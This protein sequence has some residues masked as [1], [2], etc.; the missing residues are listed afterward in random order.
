VDEQSIRFDSL[1]G[2]DLRGYFPSLD[3]SDRWAVSFWIKPQDINLGHTF[4]HAEEDANNF[5]TFYKDNFNRLFFEAQIAGVV[6]AQF[7][8]SKFYPLDVSNWHHIYLIF[9][10]L[11]GTLQLFV[12]GNIQ[13]NFDFFTSPTNIAGYS[14]LAPAAEHFVGTDLAATR[15]F[16]GMMADLHCLGTIPPGN[17]N[18]FGSFDGNGTWIRSAFAGPWG[19]E[20]FNLTFG[21][22]IDLGEDFSGNSNDFPVHTNAAGGGADQFDDWMERNYAILDRNDPR[23]LGGITEGGLVL[24]AANGRVTMRPPANSGVYY[25]ERNGVAVTFDT[26]G[27]EFD[28]NLTPATYNFGQLPFVDVGPM[29]GELT[30]NGLNLPV[31]T[32]PNARAQFA[33]IGYTGNATN[34]RTIINGSRGLP[35]HRNLTHRSDYVWVKNMSND[36]GTFGHFLQHR[37]RPG[38]QLRIDTPGPEEASNVDGFL[39]GLLDPGP[40]FDVDAGGTSDD[41]VNHAVSFYSAVSWQVEQYAQNLQLVDTDDDSE[42]EVL[43]GNTDNT[44]SDLEITLEGGGAT[45]QLVGIRFQDLRIPQGATIL[46]ARIQFEAN[47]T[48]TGTNDVVIDCEDID[49]APVF[50]AGAANF[51]ISNRTLTGFTTAWSPADWP[52]FDDRLAPQLTTDFK[53]SVQDV[54]DRG[55]WTEG[56]S[57]VIVMVAGATAGEREAAAEGNGNSAELQ[58]RW[59][60]ATPVPGVSLFEYDG[61][62]SGGILKARNVM[63]GLSVVPEFIA[64]KRVAGGSSSWRIYVGTIVSA[65]APEDGHLEFDSSNAYL[66]S[67]IWDNTAPGASFFTVGTDVSINSV[68]GSDVYAGFAMVS[69]EAFSKVFRYVGNNSSN[70]PLVYLGFKPRF[71]LIKSTAAGADWVFHTKASG[72]S[73]AI[74]SIFNQMDGNMYLNTDVDAIQ[75][76]SINGYSRGFQIRDTAPNLNSNL[77]E[78]I[79]I[80]FAEAPFQNAKGSL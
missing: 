20:G 21:R 56:N 16:S 72:K 74:E 80:A 8:V 27:G 64:V 35:E 68:S 66:A 32:F 77:Q 29:G 28:P 6:E 9:N 62:P 70:G 31:A 25:Y 26:V 22:T 46:E 34:P 44:S 4:L 41:N 75:L 11:T 51:N 49:N 47:D 67:A 23:T 69:V 37:L 33:A 59:R 7:R 1:R 78:Y 58:V 2:T 36:T 17:P 38:V 53:A 42:E 52:T 18:G 48:N 54:V 65:G 63:H 57:L 10:R 19:T 24:T 79:G 60:L 45:A 73:D 30:V 55:G 43:N 14:W 13:L 61:L 50:V 76:E 71:I 40:G 12:N 3:V 15:R 5:T 39:D